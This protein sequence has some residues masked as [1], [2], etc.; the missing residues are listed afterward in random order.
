MS[1]IGK[2]LYNNV[3][4]AEFLMFACMVIPFMLTYSH[5]IV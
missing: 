2:L 1:F 3:F 5:P 4:D